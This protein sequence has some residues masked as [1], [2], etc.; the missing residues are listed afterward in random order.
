MK[1]RRLLI[2]A[3]APIA[4]IVLLLVG[5][6]LL[7]AQLWSLGTITVLLALVGFIYS[8]RLLESLPLV[9]EEM[10]VLRPMLPSLLVWLLVLCLS[11]VAVL[12]VAD[13]FKSAQTDHVAALAFLGSVILGL[14]AVWWP[15]S[16]KRSS[17]LVE[18]IKANRLE[19]GILL[20]V[21][22]LALLLRTIDL[23]SHPY[24]WSG[25]EASIGMEAIR[26]LNGEVS[27]LF[28]TGWSSQPNWSFVPTALMEILFGKSII[29]IR[30]VSALVGTLAV[31]FVYLAGREL[32]NPMVGLMAGSFL[33]TL[34]YHVHFSRVGVHNI[35]DSLFSSLMF[36]LIARGIKKDDARYYYTAGAV[37]GLSIYTYAGTRLVLILAGVTF[38]FLMVRQR[39][40]L[41]TH[42]RHLLWFAA[43]A[44]ISAAP[45]AAFFARHPDIFM[46]RFGQEGIFLNGW[47]AGQV[48]LTGK[49]ALEILF[50]QFAR[51][52]LVFIASAAPGNF[53]N[54]PQPYLTVIGSILFLAGMAYAIAYVLEPRYFILL[55][56]FWAVILFG[57]I[58]T[59]NPPANT[60]LLMTTPV[61]SLFM[62]LGAYKLFE[63]LQRLNILQPRWFTPVLAVLTFV[64]A[65]QGIHD[66]MFDYRTHMYFQDANGEFA[67]E[68]G[69]MVN[70]LGNDFQVF[71]L[72][73]PRI[74][75]GFPTLVFLTPNNPRSDLGV[76]NIAT[77][78][79]PAR[80]KAVFFAIPENLVMLA[81]ITQKYPG[82]DD[83]IVYRKPNPNEILF[84]YYILSPA[85]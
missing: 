53:F 58:L 38:L 63:Y 67:L 42:W 31:L 10:D 47:L 50:N 62:A 24:P 68:A 41:P 76:N 2:K 15:L 72:G 43:G 45:Q 60:R 56:W 66:Y 39:K 32:F 18:K 78:Q 46:G 7:R 3:L 69:K 9:S 44:A 48:A 75:S 80:Q 17:R 51:T 33:A 65:Y 8:I 29:A 74:F 12:Y 37:A 85:D 40:Y 21:L 82:G 57:G 6:I 52:A 30:M 19:V 16:T 11:L 5:V 84:E 79:L 61:L 59:L 70:A 13:N 49:S 55:L 4:S 35:V 22:L 36:W 77:F 83:G 64:I 54:S 81:E 23:S 28:D 25:D 14:L 27:N 73:E 20:V 34:P 71:I 1:P 26:M